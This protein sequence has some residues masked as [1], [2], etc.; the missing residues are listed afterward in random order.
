MTCPFCNPPEDAIVFRSE[1]VVALWDGYPVSRGHLLLVPRRHV[2]TWFDATR[3]EQHALV[4]AVERARQLV[5]AN[6]DPD[7]Y[8][9]GINVGAAAGQTVPHLHLH[10]IPRYNGD[11]SDPIGGVRNVIPGRGNYLKRAAGPKT[12]PAQRLITGDK[13]DP[14]L[15]HLLR[16]IERAAAVDVAVGFVMGKGWNRIQGSIAAML[17]RQETRFRL[18]TGDTLSITE[19]E[20]LRSMLNLASFHPHQTEIRVFAGGGQVFHPKAYIIHDLDGST[21]TFVGS[22]N[23]SESALTDGIEWNYTLLTPGECAEAV[24]AFERLFRHPRTRPLSEEWLRSYELTRQPLL[25]SGGASLAAE[26]LAPEP[27]EVPEPNE[28]QQQALDALEATRREGNQAG[29]VVLATGL[30]KTYLAAFDSAQ[31]QRVLFVAHRE[32]ILRQARSTFE[33]VRPGVRLGL[34]T[35]QEKHPDAQILFASVATLGREAHLKA[36]ARDA[37]DYVVIDEFHHASA[38]TYDRILQYF[39][40]Q[41]LLGLTATPERTDGGDLLSLCSGN[42]VFRCDLVAGIQRGR[43]APFHYNGVPDLIDYK[44]IPWR[45]GRFDPAALEREAAVEARAANALQHY[46]KLAGQRTLAFCCSRLHARFMSDYFNSNGIPSAAVYAAPDSDSRL[47]SLEQLARGELKVVCCVDMFNE[48]VDLPAIDTV[49]MLRPTESRILWLQQLGRGLRLA[50]LKQHLQVID[51]VGNHRVFLS[52]AEL[53]LSLAGKNIALRKALLELRMQLTDG[54]PAGCEVT[55]DTAAV[56]LLLGLVKQAP[57]DALLDFYQQFKAAHGRRPLAVEAYYDGYNPAT[58]RKRNGSWFGFAEAQGDRVPLADREWLL[59]LEST[60]M[61]RSYKMVLVQALLSLEQ[62]PGAVDIDTLT[63]EFAAVARRNRRLV[64][65][66]SVDLSDF[67]AL[68]SLIVDNPIN[69]WT[70]RTDRDGRPYFR[71]DGA[72]LMCTVPASEGLV[73][74]TQELVR[75]RLAEYLDR[76]A[77]PSASAFRCKVSHTGGRTIL[78]F[79]RERQKGIPT[80]WTPI[81]VNGEAYEANFVK[82]AVNV[83]RRPG[84]EKNVLHELLVEMFGPNAGLPGTQFFVEFGGEPLEMRA[85]GVD[86]RDSEITGREG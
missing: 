51:Y 73:E 15:P 29:L 60:R 55:Y 5:E 59:E 14:L 7:G 39:Q 28:I 44:N 22:S 12:A 27:L 61:T 45:N 42:L 46:R 18:L 83:A 68:K 48:G 75:W 26:T 86:H 47:D 71:W 38:P 56:D 33:R 9:I 6:H 85:S 79:D 65:D 84:E 31:F 10:V 23:L 49:L 81:V 37:F 58:A 76:S 32:E 72:T 50:P 30:G 20:P 63:R 35:G 2:H 74:L 67:A 66:V 8:N 40:P 52:K 3:E 17:Q 25:Q 4:D 36:F 82:M 41:F 34:Y 1:L 62:F 70:A 53:L 43:L 69:A 19:P 64:G 13:T 11:V 77:A 57:K 78:F 24:A 80:G 54:L 21:S 16:R